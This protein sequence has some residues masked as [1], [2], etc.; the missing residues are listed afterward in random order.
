MQMFLV[1]KKNIIAKYKHRFL[2]IQNAQVLG[3]LKMQVTFLRI[4]NS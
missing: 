2:R 1:K 4:S 3:I